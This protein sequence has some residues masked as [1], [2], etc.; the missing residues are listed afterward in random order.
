MSRDSL[1]QLNLSR[2]DPGI[3]GEI[4]PEVRVA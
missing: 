2:H 1:K 3:R 4:N